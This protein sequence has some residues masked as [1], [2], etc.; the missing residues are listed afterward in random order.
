GLSICYNIVKT[1]GGTL[2]FQSELNKGTKVTVKLPVHPGEKTG[3]MT[4]TDAS[5]TA[6]KS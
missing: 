4:K 6:E 5:V 1:H 3:D 2:N